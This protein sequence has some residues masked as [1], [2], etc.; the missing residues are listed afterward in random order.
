MFK[1]VSFCLVFI[2]GM[3][4]SCYSQ[5]FKWIKQIG[6][7]SNDFNPFCKILPDGQSI[8]AYSYADSTKIEGIKIKSQKKVKKWKG[9]GQKIN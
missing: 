2:L 7:K 5:S 9:N 4:I 8:L 6:D 3:T 1:R